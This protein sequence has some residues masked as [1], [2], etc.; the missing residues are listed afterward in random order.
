MP[1]IKSTRLT[2]SSI[3][4][5]VPV[6]NS[7]AT[8]DELTTRIKAVLAPVVE[9]FEIIFVNDGSQDSSWEVITRQTEQK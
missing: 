5:I 1:N 8:L 9:H 3:S 4:I 6:Y 7:E 2:P